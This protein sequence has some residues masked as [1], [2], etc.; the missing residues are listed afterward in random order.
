V[1][2]VLVRH[3]ESIW[4]AEARW[5]GHAD[6]PLSEHGRSEARRL[7]ERLS[8]LSFEKCVSSDLLRTRETA[9]LLGVTA[10]FDASIR[11][12]DLG[13]WSG[14]LH[15]DVKEKFPDEVMAFRQGAPVKI[16]GGE[17][18]PEFHQRVKTAFGRIVRSARANER[19]LVVTHGG[20][21]RAIM[22]ELLGMRAGRPF[23]GAS[24]TSLTHLRIDAGEMRLV[25]Y[26]CTAHLEPELL[27]HVEE[28]TTEND[29]VDRTIAHL[30]LSAE[31]RERFHPPREGTITRLLHEPEPALISFAT[32]A[33][34]EVA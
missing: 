11:E 31:A 15:S 8:G 30:G 18:I 16:G 3:A 14:L 33:L 19:V 20:V 32:P 17:S 29:V 22:M 10:E 5:Q 2:I 24:N 12:M 7:S 25:A 1:E 34:G 9:T 13:S 6:I 23:V 21:I 28:L 26:N 4:N 27:S